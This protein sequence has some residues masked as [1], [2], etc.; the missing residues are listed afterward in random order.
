[1][2]HHEKPKQSRRPT[3]AIPKVI[4]DSKRHLATAEAWAV[5]AAQVV[6]F[7]SVEANPKLVPVALALQ[8]MT[9]GSAP[10]G[11]EISTWALRAE[12]SSGQNFAKKKP[13]TKGYPK[14]DGVHLQANSLTAISHSVIRLGLAAVV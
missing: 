1:M 6:L 14:A 8:A 7:P 5:C 11:G 2:W 3:G 4:P 13:E 12:N 10:P 9:S